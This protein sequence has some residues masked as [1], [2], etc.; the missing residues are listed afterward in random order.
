MAFKKLKHITVIC[1]EMYELQGMSA[2]IDYINDYIKRYP[3]S[4]IEF[5]QCP[6]CET[7]TPYWHNECLICGQ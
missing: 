7:Q 3:D 1:R 5:R 2:V 4:N 6:H